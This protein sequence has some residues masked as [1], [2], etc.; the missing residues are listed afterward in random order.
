MSLAETWGYR[1]RRSNPCADAKRFAE[2]SQ[3]AAVWQHGGH[4]GGEC[5]APL[6]LLESSGA[7]GSGA[8]V[9]PTHPV[10]LSASGR[11]ALAGLPPPC[12]TASGSRTNGMLP[13]ERLAIGVLHFHTLFA[14]TS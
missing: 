14:A 12:K 10:Y 6:S 11:V 13:L 4:R 8:S 2:E 3:S 7:S 1:P 5:E 9:I